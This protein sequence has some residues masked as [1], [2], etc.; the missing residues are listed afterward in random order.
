M[1]NKHSHGGPSARLGSPSVSRTEINMQVGTCTTTL[2]DT[3]WCIIN[4]N[5]TLIGIH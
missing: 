5:H 4:I 2:D 3:Y 1:K